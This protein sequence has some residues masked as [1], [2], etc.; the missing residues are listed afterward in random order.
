MCV[1]AF[2]H[3]G[4]GLSPTPVLLTFS[5]KLLVTAFTKTEDY[6]SLPGGGKRDNWNRKKK[7]CV[8]KD[9]MSIRPEESLPKEGTSSNSDF[10]WT[11]ETQSGHHRP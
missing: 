6:S 3:W 7:E 10:L 4:L 8:A 2:T 5:I 9:K 1:C 11:D